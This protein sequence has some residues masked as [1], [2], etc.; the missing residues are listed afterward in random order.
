M[1]TASGLMAVAELLERA[2]DRPDLQAECRHDLH[3]LIEQLCDEIIGQRQLLSAEAGELELEITSVRAREV[4]E[5]V[6]E[7]YRHASVAQGR[8]L[9]VGAAPEGEVETDPTLLRRVLGNL[10][11]NALE[12]TPEGGT[13]TVWAEAQGEQVAFQVQNPGVMAPDVQMQVF[14]RSFSTKAE[15]GRGVGTHSARL[16]TESYLG[17]NITFTSQEPEGTVFTVLLPRHRQH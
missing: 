9:E 1:N 16:L 15:S 3:T 2:G 13:V 6:A 11:R 4:L 12:A 7:M 5:S 17:G 14:Q 8:H 10:V